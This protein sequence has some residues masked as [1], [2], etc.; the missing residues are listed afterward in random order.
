MKTALCLLVVFTLVS[1]HTVASPKEIPRQPLQFESTPHSDAPLPP[2]L[3]A[4][5][6]TLQQSAAAVADTFV[7]HWATFDAR[8]GPDPMDYTHVDLTTQL[9][10][11]FHVADGVELDGGDNGN[12]NP[13]SGLRSMWCGVDAS[14]AAPY[15][16]YAALPGYGNGWKQRLESDPV[17]GDSLS[18][19]YKVFWDSEE[20]Y[21]YTRVEYTFD[22]GETWLEFPLT[23]GGVGKPNA[24][25]SLGTA[26]FITENFTVNSPGASSVRVRFAFISDGAWSDEDGLWDTDGAIL[27]DDIVVS[28]WS[29]GS[30]AF[31]NVEDFESAP[32]GGHTAGIWTGNVEPGFGDFAALY[33]GINV[34]QEDPCQ[35]D[36]D[37]IWGFFDDPA[38]A[39]YIYCRPDPVPWQGVVPFGNA[40]GLYIHNQIWSPRFA[41]TGSGDEYILTFRVYRDLDLNDL[42]FYQWKIRTYYNGCPADWERL[43]FV[44][45]GG[46]KDWLTA[47]FE[48]GSLVGG[49][50]ELQIA[51]GVFDACEIWCNIYGTPSLCRS[52]GP[53]FDDIRLVRVNTE[54][55]RYTV[56]HI[57]L[58]QDNFADDGTLTG[59]ARADAALDILP[60]SSPGIQPGDSTVATVWPV[61]GPA[62]AGPSAWLH[63]RVHNG[64]APKSG[65][66]LGSADTRP[67]KAGPRWPHAGSWVDADGDTW[68]I[69]QMDTVVTS[70]GGYSPDRYCV[71]LNDALFVP[72]DT[73]LYF[74]GADV[75]GASGNGNENYWHRTIGGQ[76]EDNVTSDIEEAAASPCEF[77]ILPAGGYNRGGNDLYVDDTDDRG[78]PAQLFFDSAFDMIGLLDRVDRYDVLGPSSAAGNSLA[79]RVKSNINQIINTYQTIIWNSGNL[80]SATIGDGTGYPEKSDDFGL[81]EQFIRTSVKDPLLYISGDDI[82]EEWVTLGG[83]GAGLLRSNWIPFNLLDGDHVNF[84]ET[85]SPTLTATGSWFTPP[86]GPQQLVVYGGCPVINDFDVLQPTGVSIE[87]FPYPNAGTGNGAAVISAQGPNAQPGI[88]YAIMLSGFSYHNIRDAV[89]AFPPVRVDHLR[90]FLEQHGIVPEPTGIDPDGGPQYANALESNYPNP[91]NPVTT[92][93]YSIK[94]RA[95]VS[96]KIYNAAGQLVA[97][98]V[99]EVRSPDRVKPV[100]WHGTNNTG[101]QVS[102]GVYFYKLV[103]KDFSKTRKMVFL[104]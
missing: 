86:S 64:N 38:N 102:S 44:Y 24:Y 78:G 87:Q 37:F 88:H 22:D 39:P 5:Y 7:L 3:A 59:T 2:D 69:F 6:G 14:T 40:D 18:I 29:G 79:S 100:T 71:D 68:E 61:H 20:E 85:V 46:Q 75:D 45:Y 74:F 9:A 10:T 42:V 95:H 15:C 63:A 96:L 66:G 31:S 49:A 47:R 50:E 89:V 12:L 99:D 16:S 83:T 51:V 62:G 65:P 36:T 80:S 11:F 67:G 82:A 26:P 1:L 48:V 92:I 72:G 94:E 52:H 35:Y 53:L 90:T 101:Q 103:T 84:G 93:R 25:D 91:F 60:R 97:T 8:G 33:P 43:S 54:G 57:D 98:L 55:P 77:T 19:S 13:L 28:T 32:V 58:F 70:S 30:A 17:A 73:I 41:N 104:K 56:R 27:I 34:L 76:G 23:D 4:K 81:L 21:D